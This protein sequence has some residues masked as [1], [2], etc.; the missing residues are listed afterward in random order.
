METHRKKAK[1]TSKE[2]ID[3]WS[4]TGH[5]ETGNTKLGKNTKSRGVEGGVGGSK[6]F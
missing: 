6:N 2:A 1:R 5:G 4:M 3:R